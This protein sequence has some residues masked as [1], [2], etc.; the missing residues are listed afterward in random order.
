MHTSLMESRPP[1]DFYFSDNAEAI[2][3]LVAADI[4]ISVLPEYYVNN[5]EQ[6]AAI[7]FEGAAPMSFGVYYRTTK[8]N[9]S[10][11]SFIRCLDEEL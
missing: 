3:T 7:P 2:N 10:L 1:H 11:K 6:I 5:A 4:G 8:G 9:Q